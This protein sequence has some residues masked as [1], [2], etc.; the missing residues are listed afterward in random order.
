[1]RVRVPDELVRRRFE[2]VAMYQSQRQ[3]GLVVEE[4]RKVG[5]SEYLLEM[6][7]DLIKH[8]KYAALF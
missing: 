8:E 2:A 1:M 5:G 4:L 7:F 6:E 3:I